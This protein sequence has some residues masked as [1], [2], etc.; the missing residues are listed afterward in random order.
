MDNDL[1]REPAGHSQLPIFNYYISPAVPPQSF[2]LHGMLCSAA[3]IFRN[4]WQF[5]SSLWRRFAV[6]PG[7]Q[8]RLTG[9]IEWSMIELLRVRLDHELAFHVLPGGFIE[10]GVDMHMPE[11]AVR[12]ADAGEISAAFHVAALVDLAI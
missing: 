8:R 6:P 4:Q 2:P 10:A 9:P 11:R 5:S 1:L 12:R 3:A 7:V